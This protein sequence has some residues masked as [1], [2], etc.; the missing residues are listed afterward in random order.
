MDTTIISLDSPSP[1]SSP[2]NLRRN[3]LNN[4][5]S[6]LNPLALTSPSATSV[7]NTAGTVD[8][9]N[10]LNTNYNMPDL[11]ADLNAERFVLNIF[12]KSN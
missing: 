11:G 5:G 7:I 6:H 10:D 3:P 1:P 4:D 8:T 2:V 12:S 9:N